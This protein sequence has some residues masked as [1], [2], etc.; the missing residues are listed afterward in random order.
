MPFR[1]SMPL[2]TFSAFPTQGGGAVDAFSAERVVPSLPSGAS[3]CHSLFLLPGTLFIHR[4]GLM[5]C[6]FSSFQHGVSLW[7]GGEGCSVLLRGAPCCV[8]FACRPVAAR[9]LQQTCLHF[10]MGHEGAN[11]GRWRG[12]SPWN[13]DAVRRHPPS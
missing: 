5:R 11:W 8:L 6:G 9:A 2:L 3:A 7:R 10:C 13:G 4:I 1:W 12:A